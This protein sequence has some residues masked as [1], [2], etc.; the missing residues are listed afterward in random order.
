MFGGCEH[1]DAAKNG[2]SSSKSIFDWYHQRLTQ[3]K[4]VKRPK[5]FMEPPVNRDSYEFNLNHIWLHSTSEL[6]PFLYQT[7]GN[8]TA[9]QVRQLKEWKVKKNQKLHWLL[10]RQSILRGRIRSLPARKVSL[11]A[12]RGLRV[13]HLCPPANLCQS[14]RLD[15][16]STYNGVHPLKLHTRGFS[17]GGQAKRSKVSK[18]SESWIPYFGCLWLKHCNTCHVIAPWRVHDCREWDLHF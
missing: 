2:P 14:L 3:S 6:A 1:K 16:N 9:R 17:E 15:L 8:S 18:R 5:L 10:T 4:W 7:S 13:P 11:W 12:A